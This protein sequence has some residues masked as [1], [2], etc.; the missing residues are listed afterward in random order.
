M[1]IIEFGVVT[2]IST[3]KRF[4]SVLPYYFWKVLLDST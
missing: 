2:E 4:K 3:A 1:S